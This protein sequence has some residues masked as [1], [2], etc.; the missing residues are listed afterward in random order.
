MDL[1]TFEALMA[2]IK[3]VRTR[4]EAPCLLETVELRNMLINEP[5]YNLL[6]NLLWD[7][8]VR[9]PRQKLPVLELDLRGVCTLF[10]FSFSLA[11][12]QESSC[13]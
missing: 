9:R 11:V 4:A 6:S 12:L 1:I 10:G 13:I 2:L 5:K 8:A 7:R 3:A